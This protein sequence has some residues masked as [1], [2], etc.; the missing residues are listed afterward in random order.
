MNR[1]KVSK[2]EMAWLNKLLDETVPKQKELTPE[3]ESMIPLDLRPSSEVSS[4]Y[5]K[6]KLNYELMR[7]HAYTMEEISYEPDMRYEEL[8]V[9]LVTQFNK[10]LRADAQYEPLPLEWRNDE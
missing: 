9:G 10:I 1:N 8:P 3:E 4:S 2:T 5:D 6:W 7:L